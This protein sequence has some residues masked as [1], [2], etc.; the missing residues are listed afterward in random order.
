[1]VDLSR[2]FVY[3]NERVME[4]S[5]GTDAGASIRD[6]IKSIAQW[7]VCT[8]AL[9]PYNIKQYKV[10]PTAACYHDAAAR[11]FLKYSR[12]SRTVAAFQQCLASGYPIVA[13]ITVYESIQSAAVA[14]SGVLPMP[15]A[16]E[17]MLGGHAILIV[18][19]DKAKGTFKVRNSWGSGW[20]QKGYFTIPAEYLMISALASD[21]WVVQH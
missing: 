11:R 12:V 1:M 13:G 18:G 9:W 6:G 10:H 4:G 19:Y 8:E 3:Y 17:K 15:R 16:G 7:G 14:A 2:L 5:V 21:F 20:G